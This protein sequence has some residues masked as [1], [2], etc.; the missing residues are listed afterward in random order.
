MRKLYALLAGLFMVLVG[1]NSSAQSVI[2]DVA[3][4]SFTVDAPNNNVAFNNL[5]TIGSLPGIRK[6][7]WTFGDGT[8]QWTPALANTSHHYN[9]SGNYQVCLKIYRYFNNNDSA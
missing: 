6:A 3:N 8:S 5:S 4:F 1:N 2:P 9:T 7:L